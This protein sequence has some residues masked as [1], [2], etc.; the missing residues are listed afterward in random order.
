M[1]K[2]IWLH[3]KTQGL[4]VILDIGLREADLE[5]MFEYKRLGED[6]QPVGIKFHRPVREFLDGQ[7]TQYQVNG[8]GGV[9]ED[10][11]RPAKTAGDPLK[12]EAADRLLAGAETTRNAKS[13]AY[14]KGLEEV[15]VAQIKT[16][17]PCVDDDENVLKVGD[18]V[19]PAKKLSSEDSKK[20][21]AGDKPYEIKRIA[22]G[23]F[24][25]IF[26]DSA[27][28]ATGWYPAVF[29]KVDAPYD[30]LE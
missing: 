1:E 18:W 12:R 15:E 11:Q 27:K 25:R 28:G 16:G 4:Y 30:T 2:T 23:D 29:R 14:F 8:V 17:R 21:P 20:L 9:V 13:E 5:P 19:E 7:F 26:F 24:P 22:E 3:V 10:G 6:N